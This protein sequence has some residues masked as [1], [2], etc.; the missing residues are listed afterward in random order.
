MGS[1]SGL[2]KSIYDAFKG[3]LQSG[4]LRQPVIDASAGLDAHGDPVTQSTVDIPVEG[5]TDAY[6]AFA[7]A[8]GIPDTDLK[9]CLFGGG[10][11]TDSKP[12]RD[13]LVQLDGRWYHLRNAATDPE[14][15]LWTCQAREIAAP[16]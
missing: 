14:G 12:S 10:A 16:V 4:V 8:N 15:A 5:F 11:M 6:S 13:D 9:V 1:F 2:K 7:K 3:Q